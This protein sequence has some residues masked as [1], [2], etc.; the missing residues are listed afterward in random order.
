MLKGIDFKP[1][2]LKLLARACRT[3][4]KNGYAIN[5]LVGNVT[6]K[7]VQQHHGRSP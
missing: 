4:L 6:V 5:R 7:L 1:A 2:H 3:S